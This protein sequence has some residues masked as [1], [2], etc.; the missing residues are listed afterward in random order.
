MVISY[1]YQMI[2]GDNDGNFSRYKP[3]WKAEHLAL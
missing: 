1:D 2:C 3:P